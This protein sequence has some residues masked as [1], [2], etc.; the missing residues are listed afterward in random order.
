MENQRFTL[1][2]RAFII[3]H[4]FRSLS[5]QNV[6]NEFKRRFPHRD[7]PNKSTIKRIVDRF[8][9][10]HTVEDTPRS[11]RPRALTEDERQE[12]VDRVVEEPGVSARCVAQETG[13]A[14]ETVRRTLRE[15]GLHPY[16][17]TTFQELLPA[18]Y[19]KRND[20]CDWFKTTIAADQENLPVIFFSDEAWFHLSGYVNSQNYRIWSSTN[21]HVYEQTSLHPQKVG[22]WCAISPQRVI[23]PI[24]F[25]ETVNAERYQAILMQ[26][27]ALLEP[28]ERRC[29]FQQDGAKAH[30]AVSSIDFLREFFEDRIISTGRWPPRSPDLTPCDYFLWGHLK[31]KVYRNKPQTLDELRTEI[32]T[33]INEI[34]PEMLEH[35]FKNL[36]KRLNACELIAGGHFQHL[37]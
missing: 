12:V 16:R 29:W 15:A 4:Y 2:Q 23:G 3:E 20:F 22:V 7:A 27:I 30:T 32:E 24:F 18:D 11:G 36:F 28:H 35:V 9:N 19:E 1:E 17:I 10:Q 34:T 37:L 33:Q 26:F 25:E 5:Y 6:I 31:N 13:H 21:P 8:R 14:R